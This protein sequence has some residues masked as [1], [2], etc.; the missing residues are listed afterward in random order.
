[1]V[2]SACSMVA[3][4]PKMTLMPRLRKV[5]AICQARLICT[6]SITEM[7]TKSTGWSKSS[8]WTFSSTK[9]TSTSGGRVAAN[10]TGPW[11]GRWNSVCRSSLG[12]LG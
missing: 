1:M 11:G 4:P 9:T 7:P 8:A 2:S 3:I 6:V 12:H 5:S 10:T